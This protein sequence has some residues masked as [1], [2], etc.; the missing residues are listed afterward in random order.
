[1][2]SGVEITEQGIRNDEI[3]DTA[4]IKLKELFP[5]LDSLTARETGVIV[6]KMMEELLE[7][8]C[9]NYFGF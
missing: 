8:K 5:E 1:M 9:E 4:V 3:H 2:K 7:K 6:R